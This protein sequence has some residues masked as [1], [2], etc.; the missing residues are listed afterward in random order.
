VAQHFKM[1][2]RF[3]R[4][5]KYVSYRVSELEKLIAKADFRNAAQIN[6]VKNQLNDIEA[7]MI[8]HATWEESSIHVL[9]KKKNSSIHTQIEADHQEHIAQFKK[10]QE[11][12]NSISDCSSAEEKIDQGYMFYIA[13]RNFTGSNL[14][15]L[16]DE[17]TIIM[18]ELQKLYSDDELR[19]IEFDTYAHMTSEQMIEMME[20]LFPHMNSS[21]REFFLKDIYDAEPEKFSA[22]WNGI[23]PQI[24]EEEKKALAKRFKEKLSFV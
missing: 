16:H 18:P 15:H 10:L 23:A 13:Y 1:R 19:A 11:M 2:Y 17:E 7:L 12:I 14:K 8:S 3:Y 6:A 21:D 5:H 22:A 24:D 9:L 4:E 20:V